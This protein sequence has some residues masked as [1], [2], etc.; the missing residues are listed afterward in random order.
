MIQSANQLL[1]GKGQKLGSEEQRLLREN[2]NELRTR[3][4]RL[5]NHSTDRTHKINFAVEDLSKIENNC[6]EFET[7]LRSAEQDLD[8]II[9]NIASDM[10]TLSKQVEHH[11]DFQDD[12]VMHSADLS[13][14]N[15]SSQKFLDSARV[16]REFIS[17]FR[18]TVMSRTFLRSFR[19]NPDS[20]LL[21]TKLNDLN[22]RYAKL[23]TD[24]F[25]QGRRLQRLMELHRNYTERVS[26]TNDWLQDAYK[27]LTDLLRE[28]VSAETETIRRQIKDL[29]NF[30]KDVSKHRKDVE[31]VDDLGRKLAVEQPNIS[32]TVEA[33][34]GKMLTLLD[35]SFNRLFH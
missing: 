26:N 31:T 30:K 6:D 2:V 5:R 10:E 33:T 17:E 12:V 8:A 28:P 1:A 11:Q 4:E 21:K 32:S 27:S 20:N 14:M 15:T 3:N 7:W 16:Y 29:N 24:V 22:N 18:H 25:D 35:I 9:R 23:K 13:L 34:S 19:E